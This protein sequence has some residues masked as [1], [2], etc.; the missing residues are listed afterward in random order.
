MSKNLN[1]CTCSVC[2]ESHKYRALVESY[3]PKKYHEFFDGIYLKLSCAETDEAMSDLKI[4]KLVK[5]IG[6]DKV[7]EILWS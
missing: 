1:R 3:V 4:K 2:K 7:R 6:I 5:A